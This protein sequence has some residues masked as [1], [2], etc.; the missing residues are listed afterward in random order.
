[1]CRRKNDFY[2]ALKVLSKYKIMV[3]FYQINLIQFGRRYH[4]Y[5]YFLSN[6]S[7]K[8]SFCISIPNKIHGLDSPI[9]SILSMCP[10]TD[11]CSLY[12]YHSNYIAP[13]RRGGFYPLHVTKAGRPLLTRCDLVA[14]EPPV[15]HGLR[16]L[17]LQVQDL[18]FQWAC[19]GTFSLSCGSAST[20]NR[21]AAKPLVWHS[22]AAWPRWFQVGKC[23]LSRCGQAARPLVWHQPAF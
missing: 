13:V 11:P 3:Q 7:E 12:E 8:L 17:P 16:R 19:T 10:Y 1:M 5:Y 2:S 15:W 18:P 9:Y 4:K 14:A 6:R 20:S 22:Q 23:R 21:S